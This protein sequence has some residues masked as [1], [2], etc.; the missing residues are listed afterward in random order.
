M[1]RVALVTCADLPELDDDDRLIAPALAALGIEG[2]PAVWSDPAVDW[3]AFDLAVLRN[4]WDYTNRLGEFLD[5]AAGVPVLANTREVVAWNTDKRYLGELAA[6][7]VPVV[8]TAYVA[9]GEPVP[10][11]E[12]EVV[13]KPVVSAG[14]RDTERFAVGRDAE[15]AAHV[16]AIHASGR[17]A[18]IQPYLERVEEAGETALLHLGGTYSHAIRK[19][20]LLTD[21]R[22][23]SGEGLYVVEDIRAREPARDEREVAAAVMDDVQAHFGELLYARVDLLRGDDGRPVLLELELTEPSLFLGTADGAPGRFAA[24]IAAR[25]AG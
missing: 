21:D 14:S 22:A 11:L 20:A 6:R 10:A 17:V 18:M 1:P 24:A 13:A 12:R 16:A 4:P 15:L 5:W 9:P 3:A 2:V 25:I 8:E 23:L 19:G 7:G